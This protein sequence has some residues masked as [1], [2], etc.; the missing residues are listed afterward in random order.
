MVGRKVL[1]TRHWPSTKVVAFRV[2]GPGHH[3]CL[4]LLKILRGTFDACFAL[5]LKLHSSISSG[6]T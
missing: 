5:R 3:L 2:P 4:C 6:E 1:S